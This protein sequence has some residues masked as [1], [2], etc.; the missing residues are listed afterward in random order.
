MGTGYTRQ[1]AANMISGN[2]ILAADHNAELNQVQA[3]FNGTTGHN[4]DGTTGNGAK[5]SLTGSVV[6]TLPIESGGTGAITASA[7]RTN[8]GLAIGSNVQAYDAGLQSIAG[9]TTAAD[10][11]IYTTAADAYATTALTPFGR[12]ILDDLDAAAVR[13]TLGLGSIATLNSIN[14]ANWSGTDLAVANGGTGASDAT[15]A[16]T[17][18]GLGNVDNTS[19]LNKPVSTDQQEAINTAQTMAITIAAPPGAVMTFATASIPSGWLACNGAAVSRTTYAALYT[20]LGGAASP[21]GQGNGTSTFNVPD[22]EDEFVRGASGTRAVGSVQTD[23]IKS[24]THTATSSSDSHTHT[25]TTSSDSHSHTG[26]TA[27]SGSHTHTVSGQRGGGWNS[28]GTL[29]FGAWDTPT[30]DSAATSSSGAHTH[31]FTT[32]TDTHSHTFTTSSDSHNH[33]ITVNSTGGTETRPRNIA[34][35]YCI[36]Y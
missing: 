12:T 28:G 2:T 4:H 32:S 31:T 15:T 34:L 20:A 1:S 30:A 36:K 9:L 27:S 26:T 19:D 14:D 29:A 5:I 13:T 11:M 25:G 6:D 17:N 24:H 8:L 35:R 16:R 18:L 22:L 10:R 33:T 3:A 21:F 23:D 7:A